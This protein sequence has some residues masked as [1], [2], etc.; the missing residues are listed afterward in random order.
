MILKPDNRHIKEIT[1]QYNIADQS[2]RFLLRV[3]FDQMQSFHAAFVRLIVI[4]KQLI[5][6]ADSDHNTAVFHIIFKVF[7][8]LLQSFADDHLLTVRT[9]SEQY[10]IQFGKIY[11][12]FQFKFQRFCFN[13]SPLA[14]FHHALDISPVSVEVQQIRIKV[15]D[16]NFHSF[17]RLLRFFLF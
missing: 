9:A 3:E 7:L 14:A 12:I 6:T 16:C 10:N 13:A 5:T 1:F 15:S 17:C 11:F 4:S 2:S 8:D